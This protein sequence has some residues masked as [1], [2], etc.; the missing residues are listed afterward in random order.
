MCTW[1][2]RCQDYIDIDTGM[3]GTAEYCGNSLPDPLIVGTGIY[4]YVHQST[5]G[6]TCKMS[7]FIFTVLAADILFFASII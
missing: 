1:S 5:C 3:G 2:F 6:Y 4:L 7:S